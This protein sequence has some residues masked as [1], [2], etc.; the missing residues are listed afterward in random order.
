MT[1]DPYS[2]LNTHINNQNENVDIISNCKTKIFDSSCS[3]KECPISLEK[4]EE[5]ESII[6][7]PCSHIFNETNI[8][9]WL[10]EKTNCPICRMDLSDKQDNPIQQYTI[11]HRINTLIRLLSASMT[12][13]ETIDDETIREVFEIF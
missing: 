2:L 9:N 4:F 10:K 6:E 12:T 1:S 8:K 11:T 13:G 3:I 7:L 5:G